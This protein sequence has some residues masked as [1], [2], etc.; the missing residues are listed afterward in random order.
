MEAQDSRSSRYVTLYSC[1]TKLTSSVDIEVRN[2]DLPVDLSTQGDSLNT[3]PQNSQDSQASLNQ[4]FN[5]L[6]S[7]DESSLIFSPPNQAPLLRVSLRSANYVTVKEVKNRVLDDETGFKDEN[8]VTT[9][10]DE[11]SEPDFDSSDDGEFDPIPGG[12]YEATD[13][14]MEGIRRI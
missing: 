9:D 2:Y 8:D 6:L 1:F 3:S 10:T 7:E 4:H 14:N 12:D 11:D 13:D 5:N